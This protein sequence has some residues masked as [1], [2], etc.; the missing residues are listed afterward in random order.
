MFPFSCFSVGLF[1]KREQRLKEERDAARAE[2]ERSS[3]AVEA[4]D[5]RISE[6]KIRIEAAEH[7]AEVC[8]AWHFTHAALDEQDACCF[9]FGRMIRHDLKPSCV[10]NRRHFLALKNPAFLILDAHI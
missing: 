3:G 8:C 9:T 4:A 2:A 1:E 7:A 6:L 5:R 10:L